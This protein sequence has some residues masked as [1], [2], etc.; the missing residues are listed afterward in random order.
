MSDELKHYGTPRHSGRY[1]WGS[2]E[3]PYQRDG[4]F[5]STVYRLKQQ[6]SETEVARHL[7]M[8]TRQLRERI[9]KANTERRA[10]EAAEAMRLRDKGLSP[11]AI[12]KRMGKNESSVRGLLNETLN[13]RNKLTRKNADILKEAVKEHQ[14]VDVG[15]GVEQ[16]LGITQNRLKNAVSMLQDEGYTVEDIRIEQQGTGKLT[17]MHVLAAPGTTQKDIWMHRYDVKMPMEYHSEDGGVTM[18]RTEPPRSVDSKRID[19]RYAE[20]GGKDKDGVIELRRGVDDISLGNAKYAQVRIAVDGTHYLKGMAVYA[21][22]LPDGI[23]IRFNTNK[24][25]DVPK[26]EVL[27]KMKNDPENPFGAALKPE[28]K[29]RL[30]QKH[31]IDADGNEQL[32][33]INVVNEQ[34]DWGDWNRTLSSQ[35]L[36]KQAPSLAKQQLDLKLKSSI[37]E[38]NDIMALTNPTVRRKLLEDFAD[39][40]D[41]NAVHLDAA[42]LPRQSARVI[43]PGTTLKENECY[44]PGYE[45][46]ERLVAIRYPHAGPFEIPTMIVNNR[47]AEGKKI[48]GETTDAIMIPAKTAERLSGADFDGDSVTLIPLKSA[49]ISTSEPLPGLAGFDPHDPIYKAYPGMHIMTDHEKG[50]EMGKVSNLITDMTIKGASPDELARA[51]RHSMV[52]IDAQKHELNYKLSEQLEDINDLKKRYQ[53]KDNGRYGG[54]STIISKAAHEI[55]VPDRREKPKSRMTPEELARYNA[56]EIIFEDTGKL[57]KKGVKQ[58]DG[59]WEDEWQGA[60]VKTT[61]MAETKDAYDLVSGTPSSTTRIEKI[62]ADYANAQKELANKARAAARQD[63]DIPYSPSAAKTYEVEV[64]QLKAALNEAKRNQPLERQAQLLAGRNAA[65]RIYNNPGLDAEHKKRIRG[66]ELE[67]ARKRV[68]AKK[69]S[70]W[71]TDKQWEAIN[72]GAVHKTFLRSILENADS[73]RVRELATPRTSRGLTSAK[74][75]RAKALLGKGYTQQEVAD[76]LSCSVQTLVNSVGADTINKL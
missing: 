23:D 29:L 4:S 6:M 74:V 14:F 35:F 70:I 48:L 45:D 18:E 32:S 28:E 47:N 1:P 11:T 59:T 19:I 76:M 67:K 69:K 53:A 10:Y 57:K 36:S 60:K 58:K 22:D 40:C 64:G 44:A 24:S 37:E 63:D 33:C 26:M 56:G 73:D 27:K 68:G 51:A 31:Y 65:S 2:G 52:V 41:G 13:E 34:G 8:N 3:N 16:Y 66:Q 62:Y 39:Q 9:S 42:A 5:L 12:A 30:A 7:G 20:D 43:L 25:S 71:L 38:Y 50:I 17:T 54:A 75:S 49:K 15:G 21:D 55:E 72:S 61:L 46:G